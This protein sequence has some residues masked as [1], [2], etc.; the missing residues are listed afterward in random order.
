MKKTLLLT[1]MAFFAISMASA[2]GIYFGLKGGLNNTRIG[3]DMEGFE[4]KSGYG[5][6]AGPTLKIDILPFLGVQGAA[7]YDQSKA[8]IEGVSIKRKSIIVPLD[9][10]LNLGIAGG[11]GIF[12]S[13]GPQFGF[14]VGDKDFNIFGKHSGEAKDNVNS[15][16]QLRN[17]SFSWNFGAGVMLTKHLEL[18]YVYS[19]GIGKTGE[20]KDLTK[21][22]KPSSR[23]WRASVTMFF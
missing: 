23:T 11:A 16:F 14:N 15:T 22:D 19:L 12:L 10:R 6:F 13:T 1:V 3:V 2:Q 4:T 7:F 21:E 20:L 17:S 5:W 18:G 9:V 8:E